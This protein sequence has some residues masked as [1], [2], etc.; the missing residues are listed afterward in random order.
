MLDG[1]G[2]LAEEGLELFYGDVIL[3][4]DCGVCGK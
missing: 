3:I 2:V 4:E 1:F